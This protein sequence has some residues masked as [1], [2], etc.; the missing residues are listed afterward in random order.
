MLFPHSAQSA[1]AP[2]TFLQL[3]RCLFFSSFALCPDSS[4][5]Y[6]AAPFFSLL[7]SPQTSLR[8]PPARTWSSSAAPLVANHQHPLQIFQHEQILRTKDPDYFL[9]VF[10][11]PLAQAPPAACTA[12]LAAFSCSAL[13][14]SVPVSSG[15]Q[16]S[17]ADDRCA[18]PTEV[19]K[20][21]E[22]EKQLI[23]HARK[24]DAPAAAEEDEADS[25]ETERRY[26]PAGAPPQ[27]LHVHRLVATTI[28]SE[29]LGSGT[30]LY[31]VEVCRI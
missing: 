10:L 30:M 15:S 17:R 13:A 7:H 25:E 6:R 19:E 3:L 14:S 26:S 8:W 23:P 27:Q 31:S 18:A 9:P 4:Q 2:V 24:D 22:Q 21:A 1:E 11:P 5:T 12:F 20:E 16:I 28:A 29:N